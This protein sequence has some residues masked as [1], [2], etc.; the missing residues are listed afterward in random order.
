MTLDEEDVAYINEGLTA[1]QQQLGRPLEAHEVQQLGEMAAA[2]RGDD[3]WPDLTIMAEALAVSEAIADFDI[4]AVDHRA[5]AERALAGTDGELDFDSAYAELYPEPEPITMPPDATP[6]QREE[7]FG[8]RAREIETAKRADLNWRRDQRQ[9]LIAEGD[10]PGPR[11]ADMPSWDGKDRHDMSP[12][13][14]AGWMAEQVRDRV[15][16]AG[17]PEAA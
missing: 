11:D 8:A 14:L 4:P 12:S 16:A 15:E 17:A 5:F 6:A 3:G 9:A 10:G 2:V 7:Y 13:E 1:L